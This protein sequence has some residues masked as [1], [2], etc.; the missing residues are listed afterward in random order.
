[1]PRKR[2]MRQNRN[3]VNNI[4]DLGIVKGDS[5]LESNKNGI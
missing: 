2:L 4:L 5:T 1:M 3:T